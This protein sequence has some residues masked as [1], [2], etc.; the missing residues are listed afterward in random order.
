MPL[1][2]LSS[3]KG[4]LLI[5]DNRKD[6]EQRL[7]REMNMPHGISESKAYGVIRGMFITARQHFILK[8][9]W[10]SIEHNIFYVR[11][12]LIH[13]PLVTV[14]VY[15]QLRFPSDAYIGNRSNYRVKLYIDTDKYYSLDN[16]RA[17]RYNKMESEY[18]I[19][20]T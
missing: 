1:I 10:D 8:E 6:M 18:F 16:Y 14:L 12:N 7:R 2:S 4:D 3:F 19:Y 20:S 13:K 15:C 9:K 11:E 17:H 5:K